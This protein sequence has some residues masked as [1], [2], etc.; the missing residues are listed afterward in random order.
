MTVEEAEAVLRK[1]CPDLKVT[2][3]PHGGVTVFRGT[4]TPHREDGRTHGWPVHV[5]HA[6]GRFVFVNGHGRNRGFVEVLR[7]LVNGIVRDRT[8]DVGNGALGTVTARMGYGPAFDWEGV[9]V[10]FELIGTNGRRHKIGWGDHAWAYITP[11][12]GRA[13]TPEARA[14]AAAI[15]RGDDSA[16]GGLVDYLIE[17]S[18]EFA[19]IWDEATEWAARVTT[20]TVMRSL[21]PSRPAEKTFL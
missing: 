13:A 11:P 14:M 7:G 17:Y 1:L 15:F 19:R 16:V 3:R 6:D 12:A 10:Y 9:G 2:A 8:V 18:P 21:D 4:L 5:R 20:G